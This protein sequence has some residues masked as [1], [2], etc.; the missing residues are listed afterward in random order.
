MTPSFAV[1]TTLHFDR[2]LR[3]LHRRHADLAAV[4]AE[5]IETLRTDPYNQSYQHR[6]RK[7]ASIRAGEG[8]WRLHYDIYDREV[9]LQYCG[10]R[11]EDTYR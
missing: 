2:L 6:I 10:L 9:V 11:R 7:L 8:R 1:C 4:Y 5:A 3:T